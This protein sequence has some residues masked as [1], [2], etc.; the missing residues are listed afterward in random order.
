MPIQG[1]VFMPS[2]REAKRQQV[3]SGA[4]RAR[5]SRGAK[6]IFG[7]NVGRASAADRPKRALTKKARRGPLA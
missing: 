3:L 1:V 7:E 2:K 4:K 5:D 6:D